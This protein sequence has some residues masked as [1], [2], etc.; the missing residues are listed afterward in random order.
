MLVQLLNG[1]GAINVRVFGSYARG[2][3]GADSDLDLLVRMEP[4][5]SLLDLV[6]FQQDVADLLGIRV[7]V[8]SEG[9]LSRYLRDR[10]LADARR[11]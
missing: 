2:N 9:G 8:V 10:V 5:R 7:D 6:G 1:H 11:L 3:P 4:G